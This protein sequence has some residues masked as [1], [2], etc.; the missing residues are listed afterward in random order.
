MHQ[1][2]IGVVG[3]RPLPGSYGYRGEPLAEVQTAALRDAEAYAEAGFDAIMVQ[4]VNDF[5]VA[6]RVGPEVVAWMTAVGIEVRRAVHLPLGVSVLKNDGPAALAVAQAIGAEFIRVKVWIGAMVGAEGLVQGCAR[7][8]L[9]YRREIQAEGIRIWTDVHD[10][11]GVP[12]VPMLLEFAAREAVGF[13]KSDCLVVTGST[14]EETLNWVARVKSSFPAVPVAVGG[15]AN[16]ENM[17]A[18]L[19]RADAVIVAS[20]AKQDNHLS[21]AVDPAAAAALVEASRR[22]RIRLEGSP[23]ELADR[24]PAGRRGASAH[25]VAS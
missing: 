23:A 16:V 8:V 21:E 5:P 19:G 14:P 24:D 7:E 20:A 12:L 22:S 18:M 3:L 10:R 9:R 15:G 1:P 6:E 4:N 25:P 17:G 2:L 13:G 11:T